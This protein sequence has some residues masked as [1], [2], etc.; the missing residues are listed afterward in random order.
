MAFLTRRVIMQ[1]KAP[2]GYCCTCL[3][4]EGSWLTAGKEPLLAA[5]LGELDLLTAGYGDVTRD[6]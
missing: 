3:V 4:V 6:Q 5:V 1:F 2:C